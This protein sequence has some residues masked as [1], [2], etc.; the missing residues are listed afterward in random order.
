MANEHKVEIRDNG[1]YADVYFNNSRFG[2]VEEHWDYDH[3]RTQWKVFTNMFDTNRDVVDK[4]QGI[5]YLEALIA[6]G[7]K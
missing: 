3:S 1:T 4:A 6:M 2:S 5:A 7:T